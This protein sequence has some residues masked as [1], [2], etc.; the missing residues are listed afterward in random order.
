MRKTI[1]GV[2][3]I[4]LS[5]IAGA[6]QFFPDESWD[7][8]QQALSDLRCAAPQYSRQWMSFNWT[9]EHW[10]HRYSRS[11]FGLGM[12]QT[13]F[14]DPSFKNALHLTGDQINDW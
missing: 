12:I 9:C 14:A 10:D 11:H 4:G 1:V 6:R 2:A 3:L 5:G 13:P 8:P 7:P